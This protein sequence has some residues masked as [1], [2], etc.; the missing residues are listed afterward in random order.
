MLQSTTQLKNGKCIIFISKHENES[1]WF[2]K[3]ILFCI[4]GEVNEQFIQ[5]LFPFYHIRNIKQNYNSFYFDNH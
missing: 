1:W 5:T 3:L 2:H 4:F